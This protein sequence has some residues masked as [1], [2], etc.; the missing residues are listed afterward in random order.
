MSQRVAAVCRPRRRRRCR[1]LRRGSCGSRRGPATWSSTS[2]DADHRPLWSGSRACT[3]K[4]PLARGPAVQR[5]AERADALGDPAQPVAVRR[6]ER[7]R[8]RRPDRRRRSRSRAASRRNA[9]RTVAQ[10]PGAGVLE[11][12]GQSPPARC[13][14]RTGP[15]PRGSGTGSPSTRSAT[16]VPASRTWSI[17][18]GRA[19]TPGC[20][21]SCAPSPISLAGK[22]QQASHLGQRGT[23]GGR[24]CCKRRGGAVGMAA[25][26]G[27]GALRLHHHHRE[28]VRDHVVQ[29]TGEAGAFGS[30]GE[31]RAL[32]AA[33]ARRLAARSSIVLRYSA[34]GSRAVAERPGDHRAAAPAARPP[35]AR[36]R[37]TRRRRRMPSGLLRCTGTHGAPCRDAGQCVQP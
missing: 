2:T 27:R 8:P 10:A 14:T 32:V 37:E 4:P 7:W 5:A 35:R 21:L 22:P 36:R 26:R 13:G 9:S 30:D 11:R 15:R 3:A 23:A 29:L 25:Q 34:A 19:P 17:R 24:R 18:A 6:G 12:V 28:A 31:L 16:G 20:G 1:A 33:R